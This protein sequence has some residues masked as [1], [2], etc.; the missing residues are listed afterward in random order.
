MRDYADE[1]CLHARI[2]AMRSRLLRLPDYISLS[3]KQDE[4]LSGKADADPAARCEKI[5]QEQIAVLFPVAESC[6]RY[7]PLFLAFFRQ[8]E[9]LNAKRIGAEILGLPSLDQ[10]LDIGP[11]SL[12][13]QSLLQE[14]L[15]HLR[16]FLAGTYLD[17]VF[18]DSAG[19]GQ[20]ESLVDLCAAKNFYDASVSF[21]CEAKHDFQTLT[22][23]RIAITSTLLSLR[24]K[25]TCQWGDEKIR[26]FL[27]RFQGALG[28]A[29]LPQVKI[30]EG[31]LLQWREKA[32]IAGGPDPSVSECEHH[33][34]QYFY[35]WISSLF[36]RDYHSIYCVTAYLWMLGCQIRNLFKI[37]EGRRFNFS[38][39]RILGG[40]ICEK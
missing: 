23:R 5:F 34:E 21:P 2:C 4:P 33:L 30:V 11:Y 12:L 19:F 36:H 14:D 16:L 13:K 15:Q 8:F 10:W 20:M 1:N 26:L 6:P 32:R 7:S 39:E 25:K 38:A 29:V 24:L 18:E 27:E 22:A 3:A 35:S 28:A 31:V 40:L 9:A 17:G 37:I